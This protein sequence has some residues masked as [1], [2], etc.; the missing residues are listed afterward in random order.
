MRHAAHHQLLPGL[1]GRWAG[2]LVGRSAEG[3]KGAGPA[4]GVGLGEHHGSTG[5]HHAEQTP[6]TQEL[7][8]YHPTTASH[9]VGAAGGAGEGHR[10]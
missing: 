1:A 7:L 4:G 8:A 9:R 2:G 10:R 5:E 3:P 6:E